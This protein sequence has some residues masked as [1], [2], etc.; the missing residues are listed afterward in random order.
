MRVI[1]YGIL[2]DYADIYLL[3]GEDTTIELVKEEEDMAHAV[4]CF[5]GHVYLRAHQRRRHGE[6]DGIR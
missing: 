2:D 6:V 3:I 4:I 5:F 1:S